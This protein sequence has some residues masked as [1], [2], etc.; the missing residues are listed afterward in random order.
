MVRL[1]SLC[2]LIGPL[3]TAKFSDLGKSGTKALQRRYVN[4]EGVLEL[5]KVQKD[6]SKREDS[7]AIAKHLPRWLGSFTNASRLFFTTHKA[8]EVQLLPFVFPG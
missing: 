4:E 2:L 8:F 3:P 5:Q 1:P 6:D 7:T